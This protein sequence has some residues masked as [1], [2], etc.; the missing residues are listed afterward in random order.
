MVLTIMRLFNA[1]F[2]NHLADSIESEVSISDAYKISYLKTVTE[3]LDAIIA[4]RDTSNPF[5]DVE[6]EPDSLSNLPTA[7]VYDH[8]IV[9]YWLSRS[10]LR[11]EFEIGTRNQY[12]HY[13]ICIPKESSLLSKIDAIGGHGDWW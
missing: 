3:N 6:L 5:N 4:F 8:S 9:V 11:Y 2:L 7:V 12:D 1:P 10:G 13:L